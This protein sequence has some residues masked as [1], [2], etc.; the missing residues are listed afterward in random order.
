MQ[1]S[2]PHC[3]GLPRHTFPSA[4]QRLASTTCSLAMQY[5]DAIVPNCEVHPM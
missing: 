1:C 4:F 3:I 5:D 2:D